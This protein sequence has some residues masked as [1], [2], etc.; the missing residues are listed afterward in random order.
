MSRDT[1]R[2]LTVNYEQVNKLCCG[3]TCITQPQIPSTSMDS[4]QS[5]TTATTLSISTVVPGK[6]LYS[7]VN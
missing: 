4:N 7:E 2:R 5:I 3:A 1:H 6:L